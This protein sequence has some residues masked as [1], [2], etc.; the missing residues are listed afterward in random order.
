MIQEP[1]DR[2][3]YDDEASQ[4]WGEVVQSPPSVKEARIALSVVQRY[5]HGTESADS[6]DILRCVNRIDSF[7]A[8]RTITCAVQ[9]RITDYF[10]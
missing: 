7:F 3:Q 2:T 1:C 4:E 8:Q 10:Q 5:F 6:M 9:K